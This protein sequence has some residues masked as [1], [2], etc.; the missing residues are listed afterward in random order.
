MNCD[1]NSLANAARCFKSCIPQGELQAIKSYLL[2]QTA[3]VGGF[4]Q[5][6]IPQN[7]Q[8]TGA[9]PEFDLTV[10]ANTSYTIMWGANDLSMTLCGVNYPSTGV[11][12]N[13]VVFTA[14]CT[15]MQFFGTFAGTTVTARVILNRSIIPIP[16]GFTWASNA[17]GT[18][19]VA[20]WDNP[21][22]LLV[23]YAELWTSPDNVTYSLAATV[24]FPT[25]T[26][27]VAA[28]AVGS[29]LWAK[30]RWCG[31]TTPCGAFSSALMVSG[32]V[33]D[34]VR[35]VVVNGGATPSA[36]TQAAMATLNSSL[37]SA[38]VA[39]K[40]LS[41]C[42]FVPDSL[43]A[44][45][46]PLYKTLG[47]DPWTNNGPF[48]ANDLTI[49]GLRGNGSTKYLDTGVV[50][51]SLTPS[52]FGFSLYCSESSLVAAAGACEMGMNTNSVAADNLYFQFDQTGGFF[53]SGNQTTN[54]LAG[55]N[56]MFLGFLSGNRTGGTNATIYR[57][58]N[59]SGFSTLA[60]SNTLSIGTQVS[61]QSILCFCTK[62]PGPTPAQFSGKRLSF[63]SIHT[64]LNSTQAQALYN[65]VHACRVSLGGGYAYLTAADAVTEWAARVV[66]NGGAAPSAGTKT[67]LQTF[68][69]SLVTN[70]LLSK[71][72]YVNCFAPDSLT[73]CITPLFSNTGADPMINTNFVAGDLAVTGLQGAN[74]KKLSSGFN[75]VG[76]YNRQTYG[77]SLYISVGNNSST[78]DAGAP[79][80]VAAD[81]YSN[82]AG[83]AFFDCWNSAGGR[84]SAANNPWSGFISG[85]R[86][87]ATASA[88][89]KASSTV[90]FATLVSN[91]AEAG[92]GAAGSGVPMFFTA[93]GGT[94]STRKFSFGAFHD[95]L[96]SAECQNLFNAVQALR[97]ALGGGSV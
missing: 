96:S 83:T 51:D 27:S 67:A 25:A 58:N 15:V 79:T 82:F 57:A 48:V 85:N 88:I 18:Q 72:I 60:T 55:D 37:V 61:G 59:V 7:S 26:A 89:Y 54:R 13:T 49:G 9:I 46:T 41:A 10:Q 16:T 86:T 63:A 4:G 70:N 40:M 23:T 56:T 36:A 29:N 34:W 28:P 1:P 47:N 52:D 84:I 30:V 92:V 12:T 69:Q 77:I 17:A 45:T 33:T 5:N 93:Q 78:V 66:A 90:P 44:A 24:N 2:C 6:L 43:I 3:V 91:N 19:A 50:T 87:S 80:L 22:L 65:A 38:G 74:T 42:V 11:G 95:G 76:N 14:A 32:T 35:R 97:V 68:Y 75:L 20:S 81:L 71:M 31:P 64:S 62:N 8:Y 73:A 94:F 39:S 53:D 21:N